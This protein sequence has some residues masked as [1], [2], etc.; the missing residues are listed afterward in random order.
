[1]TLLEWTDNYL[2]N[3]RV[4]DTDHQTL[5]DAVNALHDAH[6]QQKGH[7]RI[8]AVIETLRLYVVEHFEREEH[9]LE[10]AGYPDYAAHRAAHR[11]FNH[12]ASSLASL[13][14]Q[15]PDFVDINKVVDFLGRWLTEHILKADMEYVPYVRG[16]KEGIPSGPANDAKKQNEVSL[17]FSVPKDKVDVIK[18]FVD[19]VIEGDHAAESFVKA[20][21]IAQ[22]QISQVKLAKAKKLFGTE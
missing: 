4:I 19:T 1:M 2:T 20:F 18:G 15:N 5:F 8:G 3:I 16:E 7:E 17:T 12:L 9:F 10:Q 22:D 14:E 6:Q 13:Y 11:E 21:K